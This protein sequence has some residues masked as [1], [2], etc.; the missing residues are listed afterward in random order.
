MKLHRS[1]LAGSATTMAPTL[2]FVATVDPL[3]LMWT[4][5]V[6]V[7]FSADIEPRSHRASAPLL[8]IMCLHQVSAPRVCPACQMRFWWLAGRC[9]LPSIG[10]FRS[11]SDASGASP[12]PPVFVVAR[13]T[14][15]CA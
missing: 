9:V 5:P 14:A 8:W 1:W 4:P 11:P 7:R 2:R 13:E 3:Q 12:D 15:A 10:A 6:R